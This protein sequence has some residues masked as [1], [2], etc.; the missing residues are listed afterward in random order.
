MLYVIHLA[1]NFLCLTCE[2]LLSRKQSQFGGTY[3]SELTNHNVNSFFIFGHTH[4]Q[5]TSQLFVWFFMA[6]DTTL[7][8]FI[9]FSQ[10]HI[11]HDCR[12]YV[13]AVAFAAVT[14]TSL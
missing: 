10:M 9:R 5:V 14:G 1:I 11:L 3:P 8:S 12:C 13:V 2:W 4:T 7:I 6:H